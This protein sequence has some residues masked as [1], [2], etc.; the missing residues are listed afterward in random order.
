MTNT[1]NKIIRKEGRINFVVE[2]VVCKIC[3]PEFGGNAKY[4]I[5]AKF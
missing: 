1:E 2:S 3:C 4:Q 5:I